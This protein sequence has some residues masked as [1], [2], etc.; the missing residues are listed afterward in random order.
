MTLAVR[1]VIVGSVILAVLLLA[2]MAVLTVWLE[3]A[4]VIEWAQ[5]VREEFLTGTAITVILALIVLLVPPA[6]GFAIRRCGV[7]EAMLFRRGKYCP[8]CGSRVD[9]CGDT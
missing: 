8:G 5:H 1:K 4:G 3:R 6:V 2:N 9:H 7:C